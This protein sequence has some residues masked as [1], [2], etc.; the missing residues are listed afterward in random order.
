[1]G[2]NKKNWSQLEKWVTF[3]KGVTVGKMGHSWKNRSE[4]KNGSLLERRVTLVTMDHTWKNGS[5][6]EKMG[7]IW[8]K[9]VTFGIMGHT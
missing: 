9:M 4:T 1:M 2:H 8:K 3:V 5:H 7:R 6:L